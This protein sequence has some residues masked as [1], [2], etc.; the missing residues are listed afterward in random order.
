MIKLILLHVTTPQESH[1]RL[2][3]QVYLG[4][5]TLEFSARRR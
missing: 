4:S 3:L 5:I 1:M 2:M